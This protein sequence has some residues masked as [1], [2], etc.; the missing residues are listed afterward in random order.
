M[1]YMTLLPSLLLGPTIQNTVKLVSFF[2]NGQNYPWPSPH[3]PCLGPEVGT[4]DRWRWQ[5]IWTAT[6]QIQIRAEVLLRPVVRVEFS[7]HKRRKLANSNSGG[8]K[9]VTFIISEFYT[10]CWPVNTFF[11]KIAVVL[12]RSRSNSKST[13]SSFNWVSW[14]KEQTKNKEAYKKENKYS[15]ETTWQ[16]CNGEKK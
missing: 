1:S 10:S 11:S 7:S 14:R 9:K 3:S 13:W 4:L 2:L 15:Y 6:A 16:P 8:I 12:N 5:S